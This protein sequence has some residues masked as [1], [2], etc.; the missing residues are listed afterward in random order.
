[1]SDGHGVGVAPACWLGR[2]S[3][4]NFRGCWL[5]PPPHHALCLKQKPGDSMA[6]KLT[7]TGVSPLTPIEEDVEEI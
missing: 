3:L 1:M 2:G 4:A 6:M 7:V 5:T